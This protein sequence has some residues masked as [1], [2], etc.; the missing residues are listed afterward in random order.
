MENELQELL[1]SAMYAE[2]ASQAIYTES[3]NKTSDPGA[4]ALMKELAEDAKRHLEMLREIKE[5]SWSKEEWHKEI[6]K[7]LKVSEF[8][9]GGNKLD[10]ANLQDTLV[11]AIKREQES[12]DFYSRMMGTFRSEEAKHLCQELVHEELK[13]KLKLEILYDDLFY[14]EG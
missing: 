12:I 2:I 4:K 10:G 8:L 13:H 1:E 14:M 5:R 3:Q 6:A 7:D 9:I 11:F